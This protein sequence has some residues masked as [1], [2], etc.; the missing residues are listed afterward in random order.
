MDIAAGPQIGYPYLFNSLNKTNYQQSVSVG[1]YAM[2]AYRFGNSYFY[3]ALSVS[4]SA[5]TLPVARMDGIVW[6]NEFAKR[7]IMLNL[8]HSSML[9]N[10]EINWYAG[11]GIAFVS[12]DASS[13]SSTSGNYSGSVSDSSKYET[14]SAAAN[15]G[16]DCRFRFSQTNPHWL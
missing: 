8:K 11:I 6:S 16:L 1:F 2:V 7:D 14:A 3:P 12:A 15:I 10:T 13:L 5:L 9:N 4:A